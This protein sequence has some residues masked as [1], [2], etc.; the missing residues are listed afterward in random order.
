MANRKRQRGAAI[1]EY[2]FVVAL[3]VV[4]I[5]AVIDD[6]QA[7]E[8]DH[9]ESSAQ[10]VGTPEEFAS[11]VQPSG[12]GNAASG[13]NTTVA[14]SLQA[15]IAMTGTASTQGSQKWTS[16]VVIRVVD[17]SGNPILD[18]EITG[19]WQRV[20]AD[21]TVTS[22]TAHCS[23]NS[24][25]DCTLSLWNLRKRPHSQ[26]VDETVFTVTALTA[27]DTTPASGVLGSAISVLSP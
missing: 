18:A 7:A 9:L 1:I 3:I 12:N 25:G 15:S 27:T 13:T 26:A 23:S 21:G 22:E 17:G 16:V 5:T 11:V 20:Y 4:P 24:A 10:R 6:V 14:T 2:A 19:T 8:K